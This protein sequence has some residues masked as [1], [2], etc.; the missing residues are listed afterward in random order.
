MPSQPSSPMRRTISIGKRRSRS[1]SSMTGATSVS[2]K[3]RIVSRRRT[4]SGREVEVHRPERTTGQRRPRRP[5]LACPDARADRPARRPSARQPVA[6]R[7]AVVRRSVEPPSR[8]PAA[9]P[10]RR[11]ELAR[12]ARR[13]PRRQPDRRPPAAPGARGGQPRQPPDG[14]PRRRPAAPPVRRHGR[15]P[16][17][18]PV[19]LRRAGHGPA[20]RHRGGRRRRPARPGLRR[21]S[22]PA[23]RPG[24]RADGRSGRRR[25]RRWSTGSASWR[26][27]RPTR[28]ISPTRSSAPTAR[29]ACA[30]TTARSSTSP[31][32]RRPPARR[33]S[34]CSPR[35]S[36]P[37]SSAS[38]HRLGRSLLLLSDQRKL[39]GAISGRAFVGGSAARSR[40]LGCARSLAPRRLRRRL[41][42]A[43]D[44]RYALG[45]V[46]TCRA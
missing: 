26:S 6:Q 29:S 5:V 20:G 44:S 10:T 40:T 15:R 21:A 16:G 8:A 11:P 31:R 9:A 12:P 33:S 18:L 22:T 41:D 38:A 32:A 25:T 7:P 30:S 14:P 17:P 13:A 42:L 37:T 2:M 39:A 43:P 35:S 45:G 36:A 1:C 4:C 28:A 24:P 23:R 3:S 27:S 34:S 46:L 19:E